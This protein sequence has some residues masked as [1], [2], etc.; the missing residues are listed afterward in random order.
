[1]PEPESR[2]ARSLPAAHA[3]FPLFARLRPGFFQPPFE[4]THHGAPPGTTAV[5]LGAAECR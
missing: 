3:A 4:S 2:P 5:C 1:M